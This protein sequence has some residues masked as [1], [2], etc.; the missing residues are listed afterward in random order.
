ME[1]VAGGRLRELDGWRAMS[2]MLVIAHHIGGFQH[3]RL[4]SRFPYLDHF[5]H[6]S[7]P[8]GVD[9]FFVISGF[10][11][12]RLLISEELRY[13]S[14]SLRAFYIR[15]AFRI[16]PPLFIYLGAISLLLCLGLIDEHWNAIFG[17]ALLIRDT[18][19]LPRYSWFVGHTWSLAVEEQFY[20]I[21]PTIW[22][23]TP[24][25]RKGQTFIV[26]FFL[27]AAWNFLITYT[28]WNSL[29]S[30]ASRAGFACIACGIL[31]AIYEVRVRSIAS[32]V[33]AII[34]AIVGL[35]LLIRPLGSTNWQAAI[36]ESL[37]VPSGIALVLL[38]SLERG[39][40][41]LRTFLCNK[42]VQA[43][44][45]T[46]YG[47]YLWQQLFTAPKVDFFGN[48]QI[49][50]FCLP[51]LCLIVPLSYFLVEKPAMQRGRFLSAQVRVRSTEAAVM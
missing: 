6:Y 43:I 45:L 7:G 29:I 12:C 39:E 48:G 49:V 38:T 37:L 28:G 50:S 24:R 2:V 4:I 17:G 19:L 13:G 21:F 47:I 41:W 27:C 35:T 32:E 26:V 15:R 1:K 25:A 42:P 51:A 36:Y 34:V 22:I 9:I 18:T 33:P 20:L 8:L 44:G 23:L 3:H 31:M 16:L 11:I 40:G 14:V 10:V 5:V 30:S 46:S